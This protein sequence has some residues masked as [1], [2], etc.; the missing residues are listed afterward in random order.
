MTTLAQHVRWLKRITEIFDQYRRIYNTDLFA[1][2][3]EY[4]DMMPDIEV[5]DEHHAKLMD[6]AALM[7]AIISAMES[8]MLEIL[9]L[10]DKP[11]DQQL[12]ISL[13]NVL[14]QH[15]LEET[16]L[17]LTLVAEYILTPEFPSRATLIVTSVTSKPV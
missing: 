6:T 13:G 5:T 11:G 17:A 12:A 7:K 10:S 14:Q 15:K 9:S 4:T 1:Y 2:Y 16:F 3:M 8:G